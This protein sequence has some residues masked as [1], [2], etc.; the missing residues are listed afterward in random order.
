MKTLK[1]ISLGLVLFF[2]N[3]ARSQVSVNIN[4]GTAPSWGPV[5]YAET[6]YYYLPDVEAYYDVPSAMFIY[7]SNGGWVQQAY[8]P[9][10]YKNYDL[11]SG[12]KVVLTDYHGSTPYILFKDHKNKYYKG[13]RNGNQKTFGQKP[14]KSNN[15]GG[16]NS[17]KNTG[18]QPNYKNNS[19]GGGKQG[20]KGH[21]NGGGK[22]KK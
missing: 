16:N 12:Y 18:G 17:G 14:G 5:G 8:L 7:Y 9:A 4:V 1:L 13:Y 11:Y 10:H 2:A 20:G 22:G 15:N 3:S 6:R 19:Q 21:G